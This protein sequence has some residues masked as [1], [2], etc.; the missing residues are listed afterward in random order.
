MA[1][2][3][4]R[5][6]LTKDE[7]L[8]LCQERISYRFKNRDLLI[9]A[10]THASGASSRLM[11]NERLEFL[12]DS[13]LGWIICDR[14]FHCYEDF[15]EGDLTKVKSVVVSR[16]VCAKISRLL[17]LEDCLIIGRGMITSDGLPRS[18]LSDV[19]ESI[20]A[21][22][23]LDG[24]GVAAQTFVLRC[25]ESEIAL[26]ADGQSGNYKSALQHLAQKDY[27]AT[28]IYK[29]EEQKGPDHSKSF[30]IAAEIGTQSFSPAW[31]RSKK[32]AEQ[33]A[34]GNALAELRDEPPPFAI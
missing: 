8:A 12:G 23:Y 19:F 9:A 10:L 15:L 7:K 14:L 27:S 20:V 13:I 30:L 34:A 24:G 32:D 28:P 6:E 16:R 26:A 5:N 25:M 11:S 1:K 33:R 3:T 21:A 17:G 29:L 2:K 4:A 22:I 18:L 31:G